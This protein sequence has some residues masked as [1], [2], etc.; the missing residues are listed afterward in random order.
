[1]QRRV[2]VQTFD[3]FG[4]P[5]GTQ[6][7][8]HASARAD[9]AQRGAAPGQFAMQD[10]QHTGTG[11]FDVGRRGEIADHQ[12]DAG[13]IGYAQAAENRLQHRIGIDVEQR[14]FGPERHDAADNASFSG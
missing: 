11:S 13:G 4:Q 14:H 5:V 8:A 6:Q 1:M 3:P 12:A 7:V 9:D 2:S 10:V